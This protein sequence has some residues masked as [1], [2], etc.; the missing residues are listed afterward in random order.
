MSKAAGQNV[1]S[2][3]F[4]AGDHKTTADRPGGT[5]TRAAE[6]GVK[7]P[8]GGRD[9]GAPA[10]AAKPPTAGNQTAAHHS[11]SGRSGADWQTRRIESRVAAADAGSSLLDWL[12]RRFHYCSRD[13]WQQQIAAGNLTVFGTSVPAGR[14]LQADDLVSFAPPADLEPAVPNS[15]RVVYEHDGILLVDKP[16]LL[17]IHPS[18]RYYYHTLWYQMK[19]QYPELHF[20]TRLDRETSGLVLAASTAQAAG[21]LREQQTAGSLEKEYTAWVHGRFDAESYSRQQSSGQSAPQRLPLLLSGWLLPD[22]ESSVRK[23]RRFVRE[24]PQRPD[25]QS[26]LTEVLAVQTLQRKGQCYSQLSLRLHTGRTHQIRATLYS[27]GYPLLGDKLYG[28]DDGMF[29]R[30]GLGTLDAADHRR[31]ELPHQALQ[32]RRLSFRAADGSRVKLEL[33]PFWPWPDGN[34]PGSHNSKDSGT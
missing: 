24:D 26:C 14:L 10:S 21:F 32:C 20:V 2:D 28:L 7:P 8:A 12:C 33:P 11:R 23:K 30:F 29:I 17:P 18:G 31:L 1:Q 15:W 6:P 25:S 22:S 4:P 9:T 19:A 27:L 3:Q 34:A 16:A 5:Q 13:E